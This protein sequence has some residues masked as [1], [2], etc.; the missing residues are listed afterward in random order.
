MYFSIEVGCLNL[1]ARKTD[2]CGAR[3]TAGGRHRQNRSEQHKMIQHIALVNTKQMKFLN[4][5][6]IKKGYELAINKEG[7]SRLDRFAIHNL[8][9]VAVTDDKAIVRVVLHTQLVGMDASEDIARLDVS[10]A[11]WEQ[12]CD[13][14]KHLLQD[15]KYE[16][17]MQEIDGLY[18]KPTQSNAPSLD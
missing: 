15:P 2:P 14:C 9:V 16:Y 12:V 7:I 18:V 4:E 8:Q 1:L 5:Q 10:M 6:A 3:Q 11:H 13:K 17:I